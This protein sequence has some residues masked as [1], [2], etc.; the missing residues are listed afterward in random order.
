LPGR[1]WNKRLQE[2]HKFTRLLLGKA[3]MRVD[4]WMYSLVK[5]WSR[6][7]GRLD[8][9]RTRFRLPWRL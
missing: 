1:A 7:P 8:Y 9:I 5:T 3:D 4:E 2:S 6:S